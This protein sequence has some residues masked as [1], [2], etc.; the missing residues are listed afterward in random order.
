MLVWE[1]VRLRQENAGLKRMVLGRKSERFVSAGPNSQ[2]SL[3]EAQTQRRHPKTWIKSLA[4][5]SHGCR[6]LPKRRS[7]QPCHPLNLR[8]PKKPSF[9]ILRQQ[10]IRQRDAHHARQQLRWQWHET[11]QRRE[12]QVRQRNR[13]ADN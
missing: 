1:I 5:L 4:Q 2:L 6:L 8:H 10:R 9:H 11:Q 13:E 7:M 3:S 12:G